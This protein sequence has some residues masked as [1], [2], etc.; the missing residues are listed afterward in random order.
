MKLFRILSIAV[1]ALLV[2]SA[3]AMASDFGWTRDFNKQAKAGWPGFRAKMATRF[4]LR[5]MQVIAFV[6]FFPALLMP[7]LCWGW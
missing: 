3:A 6:I 4:D 1:I 2:V 7:T 5:D